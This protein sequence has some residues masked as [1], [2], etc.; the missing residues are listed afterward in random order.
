MV[1]SDLV[2]KL[3]MAVMNSTHRDRQPALTGFPL[4]TNVQVSRNLPLP[5]CQAPCSAAPAPPATSWRK[6]PDHA[7]GISAA[8]L[9]TLPPL[10]MMVSNCIADD[11]VDD[12]VGGAVRGD[13][14]SE[15]S[16]QHA[17]FRHRFSTPFAPT[18]DVFCAPARIS[19][20]TSTTKP[21]KASFGQSVPPEHG[22]AANQVSEILR[23][24]RCR[25]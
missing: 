5:G 19:T 6:A 14:A 8:R 18:I 13:G 25:E 24:G 2:N 16:R 12:A 11:Q 23:T 4:L 1:A 20:P 10:K 22:D 15:T 7:K 17:V 9:E 21:W 3:T